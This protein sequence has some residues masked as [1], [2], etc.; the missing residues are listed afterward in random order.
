MRAGRRGVGQCAALGGVETAAGADHRW[1]FWRLWHLAQ[2]RL[3]QPAAA[4]GPGASLF[5]PSTPP[6]HSLLT[7]SGVV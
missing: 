1:R 4:D 6:T 3:Q 5:S 7:V 2:L